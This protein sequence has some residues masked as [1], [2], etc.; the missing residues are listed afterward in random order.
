MELICAFIGV[1][2]VVLGWLLNEL[3]MAHREKP[4]LCFQMA[5]MEDEPLTEKKFFV[6]DGPSEHAIEIYNIGIKPFLINSFSIC[7]KGKVLVDCHIYDEKCVLVPYQKTEYILTQQE[8]EVLQKKCNVEHF[9]KCEIIA[10]SIDGKKVR[11]EIAVPIF[12]IR[13]SVRNKKPK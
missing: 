2:G 7:F 13:A 12:T 3:T 11:S 5:S 9:E 6:K 8:A 4:K 10:Y 1:I